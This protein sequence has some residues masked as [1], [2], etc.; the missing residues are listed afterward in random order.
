MKLSPGLYDALLTKKLREALRGG[1]PLGVATAEIDAKTAVHYVARLVA[2]QIEA[3]LPDRDEA[4]LVEAANR[5][6]ADGLEAPLEV[7]KAIYRGVA[8]AVPVLPLGEN[9]LIVNARD[10]ARLGFELEREM[11]TADEVWMIVSFIKWR[12]WVRLRNAFAELERRQVPVRILTTTYLGATDYDAL[13]GLAGLGNVELKVSLDCERQRLHAKAYLFVRRNGYSSAYVGSANLS[14]AALEDGLEWTVKISEAE[15]GHL[16]EKFRGAYET[17]WND[18]RFCRFAGREREIR[19]A[20]AAGKEPEGRRRSYFQLQP[21][22][23]QKATLERLEAERNVHGRW[24]N[25]VVA[26]TGTGKTMLAAFDYRRQGEP[27]PR[28][29]YLAHREQ[30]LEQAREVFGE[31]LL[32][33]SFGEVLAG[34]REPESGEYLFATIQSF[35]RRGLAET[36]GAGY[37]QYVVVDEAHHVAAESYRAVMEGLQPKILL[38]LTATPERGDELDILRDFGGRPADEMR[39]WHAI[40]QG[41]LA[42]F[43]YYGVYDATE[44]RELNWVRGQYEKAGLRQML[45][46]NEKR[47]GL[48]LRYFSE[49]YGDLRRARALGFCVDIEHAEFM[50]T[51]FR[52]QGVA[53]ES[54]TSRTPG[55][56]RDRA[57]GRLERGEVNVLFTVDLFNEGIDI[58]RLDCVLFLRPTESMTVFLQQLGRGLRLAGGKTHC[59][60]LDFIGNHRREFRFDLRYR[61]LFGGTR[62][63]VKRQLSDGRTQL[64]GNCYFRL[65]R[66]SRE[67]ILENLEQRLR[68]RRSMVLAEIA[69]QAE[70]LGREPRLEEFLA[71]SGRELEDLYKPSLGGWGVLRAEALRRQVSEQERLLSGCFRYLLHWDCPERMRWSYELKAAERPA[72]RA[73][74]AMLTMQMMVGRS[75]DRAQR[76]GSAR[77]AIAASG[78]LREEFQE[79]LSVLLERV[80]LHRPMRPLREDWPLALHRRYELRE[81]QAA[82]GHSRP[83]RKRD[84]REGVLWLEEENTEL[85]FVKLEKDEKSFSPRTRYQDYAI[86]E[87]LFHW[88]S[89]N[90]DHAESAAG[91]RYTGQSTKGMKVLLFL[92]EPRRRGYLFAGEVKYVSHTGA[93]PMS[94]IWK[95][96]EP[97]PASVFEVCA[98]FRVA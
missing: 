62:E 45:S 73:W 98:A 96:A 81:V 75:A 84:L 10:E 70:R 83:G 87:R 7:L 18:E 53:A 28:L 63:E 2:R 97:L 43:D 52:E 54:V 5:I 8:P 42:P 60:V 68:T 44:L 95:L 85:L 90:R 6:L 41:Y 92:Q 64:P 59:L 50:A 86:S 15:S 35:D 94:L 26:P 74:D 14:A 55:E 29:L 76:D 3:E 49:H 23:Y 89:Q 36:M 80:S 51:F 79:L 19:E 47:A 72:E 82:V 11:A 20:L 25:L 78:L 46:R 31:V 61:A 93:R 17:S 77:E 71:E 39:L 22:D 66:Q 56:E 27:R 65:D 1:E 58:P 24:R 13:A 88:Q 40:E 67:V 38:G 30:L 48:V 12:G 57:I 33:H 9:S 37:W 16:I 21:H 91:R 4:L 69:G 32:D 34:G